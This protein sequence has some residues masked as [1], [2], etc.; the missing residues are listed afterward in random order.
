VNGAKLDSYLLCELFSPQ[1]RS[2]NPDWVILSIGTNDGNTRHFDAQAYRNSYLRLLDSVRIA[3]PSA[4]ILLTVPN[5]SY[6][7]KRYTNHNTARMRGI[8]F[9]IARIKHCSVWDFYS[10]M[11]G[12]NSAHIWFD[13]GLMSPDHIH[14][15][16][17][18]YL[19]KGKLFFQAFLNT[20]SGHL[21]SGEFR[22]Q[23]HCIHD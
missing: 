9:E 19:L 16:R 8:I 10:V 21:D 1:L 6:L 11:G 23:L 2:L 3:V 12:L 7:F 15:N 18:G 22:N 4:T 14:F 20:W 13:K 5:D 17:A